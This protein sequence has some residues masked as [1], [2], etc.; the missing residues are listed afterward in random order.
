MTFS[1]IDEGYPSTRGGDKRERQ[2]NEKPRPRGCVVP[3]RP[4]NL[5]DANFHNLMLQQQREWKKICTSLIA[6]LAVRERHTAGEDDN[7]SRETKC[8]GENDKRQGWKLWQRTR[9]SDFRTSARK[10]RWAGY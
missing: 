2:R 7:S 8:R 4:E 6:F 5:I 10:L 1:Y 3:Y 9:C